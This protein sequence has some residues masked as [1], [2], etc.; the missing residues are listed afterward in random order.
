MEIA[1]SDQGRPAYKPMDMCTQPRV[2]Y[3]YPQ[4][5]KGRISTQVPSPHPTPPSAWQVYEAKIWPC[6]QVRGVKGTNS[7]GTGCDKHHIN[8]YLYLLAKL[9]AQTNHRAQ[10]KFVL[11]FDLYPTPRV[12]GKSMSN[13]Q[14]HALSLTPY[15]PYP[16]TNMP[17]TQI[18]NEP[19][20]YLT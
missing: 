7:P 6:R 11:C 5:G 19:I 10:M 18:H 3:L 4:T 2:K 20:T 8:P 1:Q 16:L 13:V 9:D 14:W 12:S 17:S 15:I